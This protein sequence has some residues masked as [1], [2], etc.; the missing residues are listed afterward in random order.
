LS[1]IKNWAGGERQRGRRQLQTA[2]PINAY[3]I[4]DLSLSS[5][6]SKGTP[7]TGKTGKWAKINRG[8]TVSSITPAFVGGCYI[9]I[10]AERCERHPCAGHHS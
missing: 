3:C 9:A 4:T 8:N 5:G 7:E 6:G 10:L 2:A 1:G